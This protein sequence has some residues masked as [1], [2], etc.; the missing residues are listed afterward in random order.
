MIDNATSALSVARK[1]ADESVASST[2]L[3]DDELTLPVEASSVYIVEAWVGFTCADEAAA[4]T[5]SEGHVPVR[6]RL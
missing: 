4:P 3:Q 2:K 1:A 5:A 6:R